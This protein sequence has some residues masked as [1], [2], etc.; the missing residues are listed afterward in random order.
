M[1]PASKH[2]PLKWILQSADFLAFALAGVPG[3]AQAQDASTTSVVSTQNP[4]R[5]GD[6]VE[7]NVAVSGTGGTATGML[8][9]KFGDG[10]SA[11]ATLTDGRASIPHA[12]VSAGIFLVTAAYDGAAARLASI[13]A[14]AQN[15]AKAATAM[16]LGS[17]PN[18]SRVGEPVIF[19]ATVAAPAGPPTGKV[20]FKFGDRST[21][22]GTLVGGAATVSHTYISMSSFPVTAT[23]DGD[24]N[25]FTGVG[26]TEQNVGVAAATTV[27]SRPK[28]PEVEQTVTFKT[29][30]RSE[31]RPGSAP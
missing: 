31:P 1:R 8:T 10:T 29:K 23:Y 5:V 13:G 21:A 7:F 30:D 11:S 22:T 25:Y 16:T 20:T 19:A 15:V 24:G 12:Y 4:S 2:R 18:P 3:P 14:A 28:P 17:Q 26:T 9:L 27:G 6:T